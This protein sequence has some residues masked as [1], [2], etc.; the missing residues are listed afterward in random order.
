MLRV[1]CVCIQSLHILVLLEGG[2]PFGSVCCLRQGLKGISLLFIVLTFERHAYK[3]GLLL[4]HLRHQ[5]GLGGLLLGELGA[6]AVEDLFEVLLLL[7][8]RDVQQTLSPGGKPLR[9]ALRFCLG[10][11][12]LPP[13]A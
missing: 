7:H 11:S 9:Q 8:L 4:H 1:L 10:L 5:C 12:R 2:L 13:A 3:H 6:L